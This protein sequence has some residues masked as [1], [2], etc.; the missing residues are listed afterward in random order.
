MV[1]ITAKPI[2]NPITRA[3]R[4]SKSIPWWFKKSLISP[5]NNNDSIFPPKLS[6][7]TVV[8]INT[9]T[10]IS[11]CQPLGKRL[12]Q[13]CGKQYQIKPTTNVLRGNTNNSETIAVKCVSTIGAN[14]KP[15]TNPIMTV[16]SASIN[17]IEGFTTRRI[18]GVI[19]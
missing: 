13:S 9:G 6:T 8:T 19:K 10:S 5:A 18:F 12:T 7:I 1:G 4:W 3:L 2:A 11:A 17:S 16:G 15:A 14:H